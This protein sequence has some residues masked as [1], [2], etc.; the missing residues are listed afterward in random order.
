MA[1]RATAVVTAFGSV[2]GSIGA[3][4]S[5]LSHAIDRLI[6]VGEVED[7]VYELASKIAEVREAEGCES[8]EGA[9]VSPGVF[10]VSGLEPSGRYF[11]TIVSQE[12]VQAVETAYS[13]VA[14]LIGEQ[15]TQELAARTGEINGKE[16][17][18]IL[19][20]A[21]VLEAEARKG[22]AVQR[23]KG[24]GEMNDDELG[25]TT[26]D[27]NTR[28]MIQVAVT[29]FSET[30]EFVGSMLSK[31]TVEARQQI[32]RNSEISRELVDA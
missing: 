13:Q 12:F 21:T 22:I 5:D 14:A 18:H 7:P 15:V 28:R 17:R 16:C 24:L 30:G 27:V 8:V 11:T 9:E 2:A 6:E 20:Y 31:N 29:D 1:A 10:A 4:P 25:E 23:I 26:L 3:S 19:D 32:V